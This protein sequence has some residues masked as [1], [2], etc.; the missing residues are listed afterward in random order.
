[1]IQIQVM[2][3]RVKQLILQYQSNEGLILLSIEPWD[4]PKMLYAS[5]ACRQSCPDSW[6][7]DTCQ[8]HLW[9]ND[10]GDNEMEFVP[11]SNGIYRMPEENKRLGKALK[12]LTV[13]ERPKQM[14][15]V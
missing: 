6:P 9:A 12:K 2:N 14:L 13:N 11:V 1:M 8:L 3:R 5:V 10:K 15:K 7:M 4:A